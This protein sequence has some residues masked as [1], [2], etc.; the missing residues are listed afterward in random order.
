VLGIPY[1]GRGW[2]GVTGGG[3]GL[4]QP[5]AGAAPATFEPGFEDYQVLRTLVDS[6]YTLHRDP[7]AGHAW[8]FDGTTF[9]TFDDPEVVRQ[10]ARYIRTHGYGG[11]MVWSLDG[12]DDTATLTRQIHSGLGR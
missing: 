12:D 4:F 1:Y 8:L 5:A 6:G 2:T 7:A 9:W 11:A 3:D 10:K